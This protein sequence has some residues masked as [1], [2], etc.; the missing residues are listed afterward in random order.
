MPVPVLSLKLVVIESLFHTPVPPNPT[1]APFVS[2][3]GPFRAP[4]NANFGPGRPAVV[5]E[6]PEKVAAVVEVS[7]VST[8]RSVPPLLSAPRKDVN[9]P[10]VKVNVTLWTVPLL[11]FPVVLKASVPNCIGEPPL[12][13][14]GKSVS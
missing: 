10:P 8:K 3:L 2:Q 7:G 1:A 12:L 14:S 11:A 9:V 5:L 6:K 4:V 13:V